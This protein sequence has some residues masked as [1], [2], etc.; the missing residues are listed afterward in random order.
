MWWGHWDLNPDQ[1]VS[2]ARLQ[3]LFIFSGRVGAPV[4]HHLDLRTPT[5]RHSR[6]TGARD[7]TGLH[8]TPDCTN[9]KRTATTSRYLRSEKEV[10]SKESARFTP[11]L[12]TAA[13]F[14]LTPLP[15]LIPLFFPCTG[16]TFHGN[17]R[18][19]GPTRVYHVIAIDCHYQSGGQDGI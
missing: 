3:C 13:Q 2:S 15:A 17:R 6:A 18:S 9:G 7:A 10:E 5:R 12:L 4:D 1:R 11:S 14:L 8:H 19:P 16:A